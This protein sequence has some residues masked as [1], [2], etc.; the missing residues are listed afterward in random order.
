MLKG[1]R[2]YGANANVTSTVLALQ[3]QYGYQIK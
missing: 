3:Y 1:E 2:I